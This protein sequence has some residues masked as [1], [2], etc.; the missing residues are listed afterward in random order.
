MQRAAQGAPLQGSRG[1][2]V[3]GDTLGR[4]APAPIPTPPPRVPDPDSRGW[5]G[6]CGGAGRRGAL[7]TARRAVARAEAPLPGPSAARGGSNR[8]PAHPPRRSPGLGREARRQRCSPTPYFSSRLVGTQ[9][10]MAPPEP[11]RVGQE[12]PR[13]GRHFPFLS[14]RDRMG[15]KKFA[16]EAASCGTGRAERRGPDGKGRE[17]RRE[18]GRQRALRPPSARTLG[19]EPAAAGRPFLGPRAPSPAPRT[20]APP[21]GS[22][23]FLEL[24]GLALTP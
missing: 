7:D 19:S 4:D 13:L 14:S 6:R 3:G 20:W 23:E 15:R 1:A 12:T 22:L 9:R 10:V 24:P 11:P 16:A 18:A 5:S 8:L 2:G 21:R 17:R